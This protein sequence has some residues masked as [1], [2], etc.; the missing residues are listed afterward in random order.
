MATRVQPTQITVNSAL[1]LAALSA[2][3]AHGLLEMDFG[4]TESP[5]LQIR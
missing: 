3:P 4:V 1:Q 5:H 2:L